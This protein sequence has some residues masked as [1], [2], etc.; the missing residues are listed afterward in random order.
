[1]TDCSTTPAAVQIVGIGSASGCDAL[2]WLAAERLA[3][4]DWASHVPGQ[5]IEISACA[6]PAQLPAMLGGC[7]TGRNLDRFSGNMRGPV[8]G[9]GA[10]GWQPA[11]RIV[12]IG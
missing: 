3:G 8:A 2:G 6:T 5:A 12:A 4:N 1:M 11:Q 9:S 10:A 7:C